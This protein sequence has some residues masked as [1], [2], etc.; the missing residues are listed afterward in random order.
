MCVCVCAVRPPVRCASGPRPLS[1]GPF[2]ALP[3]PPS[4]FVQFQFEDDPKTEAKAPV[5]KK[6][7]A[8]RKPKGPPHDGPFGLRSP[9]PDGAPGDDGPQALEN[10]AAK[11]RAAPDADALSPK[12]TS[13][14][15]KRPIK[16]EAGSPETKG[17]SPR[18]QGT[19]PRKTG[20]SPDKTKSS[21]EAKERP[22]KRPRD[23]PAV[24]KTEGAPKKPRR[25]K[26]M[27]LSLQP[28]ERCV[29]WLW[30]GEA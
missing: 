23:E 8:K 20:T 11:E 18:A 14:R 28:P 9:S 3:V 27:T 12:R 16:R 19:S 26:Q 1:R 24:I 2:G 5:K 29:R 10:G 17:G 30:E 22:A 15:K 13:P 4:H 6:A 21:P 7:P 25:T